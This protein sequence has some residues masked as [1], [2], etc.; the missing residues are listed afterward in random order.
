MD[1]I[2]LL[3]DICLM[4]IYVFN[5]YMF[6]NYI[7][8]ATIRSFADDTRRLQAIDSLEDV[9]KLQKAAERPRKCHP[10]V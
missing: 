5:G 8:H 10:V 3:M 1:Y 9:K 6:I 7:L 2:C 4:D